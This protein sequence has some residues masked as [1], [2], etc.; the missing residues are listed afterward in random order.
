M[1]IWQDGFELANSSTQAARRYSF[2]SGS[3]GQTA[4]RTQGLALTGNLGVTR[5][6]PSFGV[7]NSLILGWG[8]QVTGNTSDQADEGLFFEKGLTEQFHVAIVTDTNDFE[9]AFYRGATLLGTTSEQFAY[10]AWHY[11]EVKTTIAT[12]TGG[13]IE[14][15]WNESVVLTLSSINNANE[16]TAGADIFAI[17]QPTSHVQFLYDDI[18]LNDTAGTKNNDYNGDTFIVGILPNAD[19][20]HT[21]WT[22]GTGVTHYVLVD[23]VGTSSPSDGTN[24]ISSDQ[25]GDKD[26]FEFEDLVGVTGTVQ[27]VMLEVQAAMAAAGSRTIRPFFRSGGGSEANGTSVAVSSQTFASFL[28]IFEDDP[29]AVGDW[30]VSELD[31]GEWGVEVIS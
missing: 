23:D 19:G 1:R 21:D 6:T 17:R 22:P 27:A 16:G 31:G 14:L 8:L 9:L 13:S 29:V 3:G 20:T 12:G 7:K 18:Y 26:S 30:T 10:D 11:F 28:E 4:G 5:V 25:N 24:V 2:V 15:R